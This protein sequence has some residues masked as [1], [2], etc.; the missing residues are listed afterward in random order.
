MPSLTTGDADT[1]AATAFSAW[2]KS[3]GIADGTT[4][5]WGHLLAEPWGRPR[6]LGWRWHGQGGPRSAEQREAVR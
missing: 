1:M 2:A 5:A 4:R 6:H 3:Y